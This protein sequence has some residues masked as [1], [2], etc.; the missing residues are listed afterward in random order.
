MKGADVS[1]Y[2]TFDNK[3][4]ANGSELI[5][6]HSK[7]WTLSYFISTYGIVYAKPS[8]DLNFTYETGLVENKFSSFTGKDG[9]K[10]YLD[11]SKGGFFFTN[12]SS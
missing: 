4:V 10:I 3:M 8:V 2:F 5:F 1:T 7:L 11:V 6:E 12:F 9:G